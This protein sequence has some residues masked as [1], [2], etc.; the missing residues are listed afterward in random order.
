MYALYKGDEFICM[1]TLEYIA[2]YTGVKVATVRHLV[3][4]SYQKRASKNSR[5]LVAVD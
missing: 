1:G 2:E 3:A 5:V 4:P